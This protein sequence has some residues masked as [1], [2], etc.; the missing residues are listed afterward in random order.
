VIDDDALRSRRSYR[1]R[2]GDHSLCRPERCD[3]AAGRAVRISPQVESGV[4]AAY[5]SGLAS[6]G[7]RDSL[8]GQ[9]VIVLAER[10]VQGGHTA[11]A[12]ASLSRELRA[13]YDAAIQGAAG[14]QADVVDGIFGA[15]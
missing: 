13:V 12:L 1:H 3:Q 6:A 10:L 14:Q 15:T 8:D 9:L 2:R 5:R 7:A 4:I 11:S